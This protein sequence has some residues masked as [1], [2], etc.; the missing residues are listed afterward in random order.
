MGNAKPHCGG[1]TIYMVVSRKSEAKKSTFHKVHSNRFLLRSTRFVLL[2]IG[3]QLLTSF[4]TV[5]FFTN[6]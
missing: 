1:N 2:N 6:T 4:R 3:L 5:I